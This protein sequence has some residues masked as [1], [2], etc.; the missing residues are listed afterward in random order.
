VLP[1][2]AV[3]SLRVVRG[4]SQPALRAALPALL[5]LAGALGW[6]ALLNQRVTGD[7]L[8]MPYAAH[9]AQY[10]RVPLLRLQALGPEPEYRHA[11]L[12]SFYADWELDW[13][14]SQ[15]TVRG[16]GWRLGALWKFYLGVAG[17]IALLGLPAALRDPWMR[18]ALAGV[19]LL[20]AT[21]LFVTTFGGRPHYLAPVAAPL[22]ALQV[23]GLRAVG[24][25]RPGG[26]RVGAVL[27]VAFWVALA[28]GLA[29]RL[30]D[31]PR[32]ESHWSRRRAALLGELVARPGRD[33]VMVRY[34]PEH[35]AHRE[36]VYNGADLAAEEVVFARAMDDA[37]DR[38][39]IAAFP[40]RRV[41][42]LHVVGGGEPPELTGH[43][44]AP[45]ARRGGATPV[46]ETD[47]P[48]PGK[49]VRQRS[50]GV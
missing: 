10:I 14:R 27:A 21:T 23:A 28:L 2:A 22:L 30:R 7:P 16:L 9:S 17:T 8:R 49:P 42:L 26:R 37:R 31:H 6:Q 25:W 20:L 4:R 41:W 32:P 40:E 19:A 36:W 33:L 44:L 24:S 12:R 1:I 29:G 38:E 35:R 47:P 11:K 5:I 45:P 34:D 3:L 13:Y 39:L 50:P 43:P 18:L 48:G 15:Y 46:R